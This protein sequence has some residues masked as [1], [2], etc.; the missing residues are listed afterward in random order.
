MSLDFKPQK[1]DSISTFECPKY[2]D[3]E[4]NLIKKTHNTQLL[5]HNW[6]ILQASKST[7]I[8]FITK[9]KLLEIYKYISIYP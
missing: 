6:K 9:I 8:W 2:F 7:L 4:E 1:A 5:I 3:Y